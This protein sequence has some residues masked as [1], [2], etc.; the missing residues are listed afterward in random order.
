MMKNSS[1]NYD[2]YVPLPEHTI[3]DISHTPTPSGNHIVTVQHLKTGETR[4]LEISFATILIGA[5]PDLRFLKI[6][7]NQDSENTR[8]SRKISWLKHLCAKCKH[9]NIC[10]LSRRTEYKRICGHNYGKSCECN[11][12]TKLIEA[13]EDIA[14]GI[15]IGEDP[16]K[17]IDGKS[18]PISVD[19]YTNA[20]LKAPKG[21]Y[22]MGPLVGDNFVRFIPGGALAITSS[23]HKV[24]D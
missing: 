21:L 6:D 4:E 8:L 17:P 2:C 11:N 9:L 14:S 3:S 19:K 24:D 16:T 1:Q 5:R 7:E 22:A 13:R 23:L 20:I 18:N 12:K 10:D 15:G